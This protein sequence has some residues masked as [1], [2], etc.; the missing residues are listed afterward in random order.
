MG[1]NRLKPVLPLGVIE[2]QELML[3]PMDVA[4]EIGYLLVDAF[5]GVA[6]DPPAS[7]ASASKACPQRGQRTAN[8]RVSGA[9]MRLYMSCR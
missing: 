8:Q 5:Q 1:G 7:G 4:S 9:L 3:G 2:A 6:Y